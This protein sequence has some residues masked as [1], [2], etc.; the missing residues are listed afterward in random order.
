MIRKQVGEAASS[1]GGSAV[2]DEDLLEETAALVEWP[3]IVTGAFDESYLRLPDAVIMAPMKGHQRF[4][5]VL[6]ADGALMPHFIAVSNIDSHNPAS[7][8]EGNQRVLR[9][10]LAD[11]AFFYD[12]DLKLSLESLQQG[13]DDVVFQEQLGS[14]AD[15]AR[16]IAK[17]AGIVAIAMGQSPEDVKLAR[18][19]GSLC[20]CDLLTQVVGEFP[21]LQGVM[22]RE[23]AMRAGE[24]QAVA[25]AI[26]AAYMPRFAGDDI[27]A[28]AC[29]QAVA[30][31]DK[32]DTLVGIFGIGQRPTGEKDPF[33]L[34]RIAL[35]VLRIIIEGALP[36]D[37]GKLL[38][39][40][41]QGYGAT[42]KEPGVASDVHQFM[43]DRL[44][45][46]F[47]DRGVVTEVFA[48]VQA[49]EPAEPYD[50]AQR[51][52][53]VQA[54]YRLPEA[55]S[56]AAA[57]K[58]IQNILRQADGLTTSAVSEDLF[59]EN[60]E[61]DLAAKLVGLRPRVQ[62]L[63]KDGNYTAALRA[64]ASLRESVDQF[65]DH[66]KVMDENEAVKNNRLALLA[67]IHDLF[68]QTADISRLQA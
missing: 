61:W 35:G 24:P 66:V 50:F 22:G 68:I 60:A 10:R 31:A 8:R 9:P 5:P 49:R 3:V 43:L 59:K 27:P 14:V 65:F 36:L 56:L 6:A 30:I 18:R 21:E 39:W 44:R 33:A 62:L 25:D 55:A 40:T 54:F 32:L 11:A 13:L 34:R 19:A 15:K 48:A 29:G 47:A 51:V 16:R 17:L 42:L 63:L 28:S 2:M 1:L 20:K 46:Y 45:G 23:Y 4:F 67:S 52:D 37:L 26:G 53:A 57:N 12:A 41:L 7:V 38:D 58:R 64:L